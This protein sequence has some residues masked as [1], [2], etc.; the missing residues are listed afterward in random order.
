MQH[1]LKVPRQHV[2]DIECRSMTEKSFWSPLFLL[3][4]LV[5]SDNMVKSGLA[6]KTITLLSKSRLTSVLSRES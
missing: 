6:K 1:L 3:Q 2:G 4:M 5:V